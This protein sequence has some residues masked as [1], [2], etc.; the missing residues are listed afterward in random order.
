ME[1]QRDK[2]K[3]DITQRL[4]VIAEN[5]DEVDSLREQLHEC[6]EELQRLDN[7]RFLLN[8]PAGP[9]GPMEFGQCI[10]AMRDS[11]GKMF[12][13][14]RLSS[15]ARGKKDEVEAGFI[16]MRN[17]AAILS[18]IKI[19]YD[20]A[21]QLVEP[22]ITTSSTDIP[23]TGTGEEPAVGGGAAV[24]ESEP[25]AAPAAVEQPPPV[26]VSPVPDGPSE[27]RSATRDRTPPPTGSRAKAILKMSDDEIAGPR[28]PKGSKAGGK[29]CA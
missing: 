15:E 24:A 10:E 17:F 12:S 5:Q 26:A 2:H 21:S 29:P 19:E 27:E 3:E 16:T 1:K 7:E 18:S 28:N 13:D 11:L 20:T 25:A 4:L 23:T 6:E 8:Q 9:A 22:A 14:P